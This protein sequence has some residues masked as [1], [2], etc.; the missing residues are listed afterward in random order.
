MGLTQF[1]ETEVGTFSHWYPRNKP[2]VPESNIIQIT[3]VIV[4]WEVLNGTATGLVYE[5]HFLTL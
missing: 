5:A 2:W 1:T 3:G 4:G